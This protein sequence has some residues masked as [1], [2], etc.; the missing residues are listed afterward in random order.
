MSDWHSEFFKELD[1]VEKSIS[2]SEFNGM[3][4]CEDCLCIVNE[5]NECLCLV[6]GSGSGSGC[7]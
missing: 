5:S 1:S 7:C 3:V 6:D 2:F 4:Y